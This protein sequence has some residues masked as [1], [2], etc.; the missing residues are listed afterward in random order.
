MI[1]SNFDMFVYMIGFQKFLPHDQI[2]STSIVYSVDDWNLTPLYG[3]VSSCFSTTKLNK[4]DQP[5]E[6]NGDDKC[7]SIGNLLK[8]GIWKKWPSPKPTSIPSNRSS[9]KIH[10]RCELLFS[11][12]SV[13]FTWSNL[14]GWQ[15]SELHK[16][17]IGAS[18]SVLHHPRHQ[19]SAVNFESAPVWSLKSL[20]IR[21]DQP[22]TFERM[23]FSNMSNGNRAD[24]SWREVLEFIK[25]I[26]LD[27][28]PHPGCNGEY[29]SLF[30][31]F[32]FRLRDPYM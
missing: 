32:H 14:G 17:K 3:C 30:V 1:G 24:T 8:L 22:G 27:A 6:K 7:F 29:T 11:G 4:A 20:G 31:F 26:C 2:Y 18:T 16:K 21:V 9:K 13:F 10:F 19:I 25:V 12:S 15:L 5:L 23:C 28:K